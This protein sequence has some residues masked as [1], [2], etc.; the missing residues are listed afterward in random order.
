MFTITKTEISDFEVL[1][2]AVQDAPIDIVQ[3]EP[4]KMTG[5]LMHLS[6][7]TVGVSIGEFSRGF[8]GRGVQSEHRCT[9]SINEKPA[10]IQGFEV[11]PGDLFLLK[12]G[13]EIYA[14]YS[15]ANTYAATLTEPDELFAFAQ[16]MEPAALD[17][18]AW[19]EP[20]AVLKTGPSIAA[21]RAT[22]LRALL[23]VLAKYGPTMSAGTA[24][25]YKRCL[26]ELVTAPIISGSKYR[27]PRLR[28]VELARDVDHFLV[29]AGPRPVHISELC[30]QFDKP[31]RTIHRAFY[32]VHGMSPRQFHQ[33]KRLGDAH[34]ALLMAVPG[35]TVTGVAIKHGFSHVGRLP[36]AV[37]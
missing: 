14:T 11:G 25:Y 5:Q 7:G 4:G 2:D 26:L 6:I 19:R 21:A 30:A 18:A 22:E 35:D 12:P 3:L 31:A 17:A 8:R 23:R 27:G 37:W 36:I 32:E 10:V 16:V 28:S 13:H 33:R 29:E 15:G 24:D 34:K 20:A 1:Q 9:L